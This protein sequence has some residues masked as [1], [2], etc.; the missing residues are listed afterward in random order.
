MKTLTISLSSRSYPIYIGANLL[1]D[2]TLLQKHLRSQQVLIVSNPTVADRYLA[3]VQ[4][5][6]T[7]YQ[8]DIVLLP[9]GEKYK[10]IETLQEIFTTLLSHRHRRQTT[11]LAL[12]GGVIGDMTGFAAACYQRG[13]DF[14]QLPTTLLAQVDSSI[15]G[16]TAVNHKLGKN[17]I[18]AF[19]QP[20]AVIAD[21][22][23][24]AT[25]PEREFCAGLAEIIKA[26]LIKDK[27]FFEWLEL[28]IDDLLTKKTDILI[29]AVAQSCAIKAAIVECDETE[30]TGERALLNLGHT[31]GHAIETCLNYESH[32]H[33]EAVA[34][35]LI[36]A[37]KL[38]QQCGFIS[39]EDV[40]R[41]QRLLERAHLPTQVPNSLRIDD[42]L[43]AMQRDK[44]IIN[45]QLAFIVLKAIGE[46]TLIT[47]IP[48]EQARKAFDE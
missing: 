2:K 15:G 12:G 48:L 34:M 16:K 5:A 25:L 24:L 27:V 42:L 29:E 30:Q 4:K 14:I 32:L 37:A 9:D 18:G 19:H 40:V 3:A 41:I 36:L 39:R 11:L 22:A 28:H 7:D 33:G 35:G 17:M 43:I 6:L 13:V 31:F 26:A 44:K 20:R 21:I 23:T 46:A 10:S 45:K 38:S 47:T 1:H 8:C